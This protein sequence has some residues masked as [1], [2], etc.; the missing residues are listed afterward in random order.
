MNSYALY[1][2]YGSGG[3][4]E[5]WFSVGSVAQTPALAELRDQTLGY[6]V[7]DIA[8][9]IF[10]RQLEVIGLSQVVYTGI[11]LIQHGIDPGVNIG[12]DGLMEK[13]GNDAI[14]R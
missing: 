11:Q 8:Q 7:G 5:E 2:A 4:S 13:A 12:P 10:Q 1:S 14:V 6:G 3:V 9:R